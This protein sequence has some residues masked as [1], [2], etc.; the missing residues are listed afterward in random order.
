MFV[1]Q[2]LHNLS[3][4][5]INNGMDRLPRNRHCHK[6]ECV[7]VRQT[8]TRIENIRKAKLKC[9]DHFW[10]LSETR[11]MCGD[12]FRLNPF[13]EISSILICWNMFSRPVTTSPSTVHSSMAPTRL[14]FNRRENE[15]IMI[16]TKNARWDQMENIAD[17]AKLD[18]DL[19][20]EIDFFF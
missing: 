1:P 19:F 9:V 11:N 20:G 12:Y 3:G 4:A 15:A 17:R 2:L 8:C 13:N 16:N 7:F 6:I 10:L 18:Y 14:Q 5:L